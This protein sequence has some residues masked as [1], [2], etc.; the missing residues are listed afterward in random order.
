MLT[1]SLTRVSSSPYKSKQVASNPCYA[2]TPYNP[3]L[4]FTYKIRRFR[5]NNPSSCRC[6]SQAVK[7]QNSVQQLSS[8]L[9]LEQC[10]SNEYPPTIVQAAGKV[11]AIGD[12]HGDMVKTL[13]CLCMAGLMEIGEDNK[14]IWTGGDSV[15]VQLGDVLDR[16]DQ[17]IA[18]ILLLR[19]L[20]RQAREQNG[21]V[22]ILNGNHESLNVCLDFRYVTW[23]AFQEA[24][25][26]YG[27]S[28]QQASVFKNQVE[29]RKKLYAPGGLMSCILAENPTVL[30]VN[31]TL[32]AHGG[33][34]PVHIDYGLQ[35]INQEVCSWMRG[36]RLGDGGLSPPPF[37]GNGR[38][39][40]HHVDSLIFQRKLIPRI[41]EQSLFVQ[42]RQQG[43]V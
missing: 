16:G 26:Y 39:K 38:L 19:E 33:V 32:F 25:L 20:D 9:Q 2:Q 37:F 22:Y 18:I 11:Y 8:I 41:F 40:Q 24:A 29:A 10:V 15:V 31:D 35:R 4:T 5:S 14:P 36:E 34:L 21:A 43:V 1:V 28:D 17:E 3:L 6:C 23:G 7:E 12:L 30:I 42:H 13:Q 27:L